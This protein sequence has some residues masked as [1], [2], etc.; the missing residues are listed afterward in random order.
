MLAK[1]TA[2]KERQVTAPQTGLSLSPDWGKDNKRACQE[3]FVIAPMGAEVLVQRCCQSRVDC[4]D[5]GALTAYRIYCMIH[6]TYFRGDKHHYLK[7]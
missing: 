1:Q 3:G 5:N 2:D 4:S 7:Q 6:L